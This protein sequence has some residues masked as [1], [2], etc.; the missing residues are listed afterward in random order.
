MLW[1]QQECGLAEVGPSGDIRHLLIGEAVRADNHGQ[2]IALEGMG[3]ED[4][5][6][7]KCVTCHGDPRHSSPQSIDGYVPERT[8]R[9]SVGRAPVEA[10]VLEDAIVQCE[11]HASLAPYLQGDA[12]SEREAP[13]ALRQGEAPAPARLT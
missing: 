9:L 5:N 8:L 4:V 2:R 7:L 10:N 1:L 3:R 11:Q 12:Q 6:L 13:E